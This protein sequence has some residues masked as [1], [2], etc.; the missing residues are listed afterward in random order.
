[1]PAAEAIGKILQITAEASLWA[2]RGNAVGLLAEKPGE[3]NQLLSQ[4]FAEAN[5]IY[6]E[7]RSCDSIVVPIKQ[8]TGSAAADLAITEVPQFQ[9][10]SMG[11]ASITNGDQQAQVSPQQ[12]NGTPPV[13]APSED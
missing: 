12:Q 2:N 10:Y 11:A 13:V 8:W 7:A 1:M 5:R 6:R 3:I 9:L 4:I